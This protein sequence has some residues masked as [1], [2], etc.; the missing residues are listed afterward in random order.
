[1]AKRKLGAMVILVTEVDGQDEMDAF[2]AV[3][4]VLDYRLA[5]YYPEARYMITI[6]PLKALMEEIKQFEQAEA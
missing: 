3:N 4:K 1:M 2:T 6:G 5:D